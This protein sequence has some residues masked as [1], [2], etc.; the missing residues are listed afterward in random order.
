MK[1]AGDGLAVND[2]GDL[3]GGEKGDNRCWFGLLQGGSSQS[4]TFDIEY[5][6]P[7][8]RGGVVTGG[9]GGVLVSFDVVVTDSNAQETDGIQNLQFDIDVGAKKM[10]R[11]W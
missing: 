10:S 7:R 4:V 8:E 5:G 6:R 3:T 2:D 11:K 1:F 9:V